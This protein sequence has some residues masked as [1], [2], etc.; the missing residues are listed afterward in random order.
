MTTSTADPVVKPLI[1]GSDIKVAKKPSW[2][3]P[4][5]TWRGQNAVNNISP[6]AL[7]KALHVQ[8]ILCSRKWKS[9]SAVKL[10]YLNYANKEW[11]RNRNFQF[12]GV[13]W[14]PEAVRGSW[15]SRTDVWIIARRE[16]CLHLHGTQFS[17]ADLS[18]H[19]GNNSETACKYTNGNSPQAG[20][21]KR[22]FIAF[23]T[24]QFVY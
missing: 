4:I 12:D 23:L 1:I 15:R 3:A 21:N 2:A 14:C 10:G 9:H 5:A 17:F 11:Q 18:N 19:Q 20:I 8:I 22:C 7:Q 6:M 16:T 24:P 13:C